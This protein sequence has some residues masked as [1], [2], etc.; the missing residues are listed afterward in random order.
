MQPRSPSTFALAVLA[1][2][3]LVAMA[4]WSGAWFGGWTLGAVHPTMWHG[5]EMLFGYAIAVIAGFLLT[6]VRNWTGR[7]TAHGGTLAPDADDPSVDVL[8]RIGQASLADAVS[9]LAVAPLYLRPPD[10]KRPQL[11]E[12][13]WP[14][15]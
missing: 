15:T 10:A 14:R 11:P 6:A 1:A 3:A 5:H 8:A 7:A 4:L 9:P 2:F 13:P 12:S